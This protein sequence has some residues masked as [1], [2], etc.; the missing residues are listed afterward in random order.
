[1]AQ[2]SLDTSTEFGTRVAQRLRDEEVIWLTTVRADGQPQPSPVWFLWQDDNTFVIYSRPNQPKLRNIARD[3]HV[4]LN[5]NSS[6]TG[7]NVVIFRGDARIE[8]N[9]PSADQIPNYVEKYRAAIARLGAD[10]DSFA[11][12][13]SVA[14]RVTPTGLRGF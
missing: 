5:F 2:F 6:E 11:Q 8:P 14:I 12:D 7:G 13:Y 10:P 4:S 3:S 1:M 9:A